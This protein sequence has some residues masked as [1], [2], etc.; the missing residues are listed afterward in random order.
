MPLIRQNMEGVTLKADGELIPDDAEPG[1]GDKVLV[2]GMK[3]PTCGKV[4]A[5]VM[6]KA[7]DGSTLGIFAPVVGKDG[8]RYGVARIDE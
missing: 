8:E 2:F 1:C 3:C 7:P 5:Q 6:D 4:H